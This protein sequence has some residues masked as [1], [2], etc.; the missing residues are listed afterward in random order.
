M[1][2]LFQ[3][4]L[5]VEEPSF[6]NDMKTSRHDQ[7][8]RQ[9]LSV[10]SI[11]RF[12][13]FFFEI[14]SIF[15]KFFAVK[16]CFYKEVSIRATMTEKSMMLQTLKY[17]SISTARNIVSRGKTVRCPLEMPTKL[18]RCWLLSSFIWES[19]P[20]VFKYHHLDFICEIRNFITDCKAVCV[21]CC[22]H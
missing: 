8:Y 4:L 15:P 10:K 22:Q 18:S 12:S 6:T 7:S 19:L 11:L 13:T 14:S 5:N 17:I 9:P 16:R 2:N 20:E 21:L 3:Y 1:L